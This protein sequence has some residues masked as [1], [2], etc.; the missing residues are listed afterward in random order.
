MSISGD[1]L[2][3]NIIMRG[4]LVRRGMDIPEEYG[5]GKRSS[6]TLLI[7]MYYYIITKSITF[8]NF[9]RQ[10]TLQDM[11]VTSG[12]ECTTVPAIKIPWPASKPVKKPGVSG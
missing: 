6:I 5:G 10:H 11:P 8:I 7:R 12:R 1:S 9:Y 3:G 2:V 4:I